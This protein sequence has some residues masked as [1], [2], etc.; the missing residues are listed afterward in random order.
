MDD[1][2]DD[3]RLSVEKHATALARDPVGSGIGNVSSPYRDSI[4][5][6]ALRRREERAGLHHVVGVVVA[7]GEFRRVIPEE[8][9]VQEDRVPFRVALRELRLDP[10]EAAVDVCAGEQENL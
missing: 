9:A 6:D 5:P 10:F 8:V 2:A 3:V 1:A 4:D 7:V